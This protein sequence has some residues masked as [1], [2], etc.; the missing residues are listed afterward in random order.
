MYFFLH[1]HLS[2][3]NP[4]APPRKTDAFYTIVENA[5]SAESAAVAD[6]IDGLGRPPVLMWSDIKYTSGFDFGSQAKFVPG[7]LH[8]A[9]YLK[10]VNPND[11]KR[12]KWTVN[13]MDV[14]LYGDNQLNG[15]DTQAACKAYKP[16][17]DMSKPI[18]G[19]KADKAAKSN[20]VDLPKIQ[21]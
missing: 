10:A 11:K 1:R 19:S 16:A 18:P 5:L 4:K 9:G 12:G 15:E 21:K 20:V 2:K 6:A 8:D 3:F 7:W 17:A 14:T 13:K